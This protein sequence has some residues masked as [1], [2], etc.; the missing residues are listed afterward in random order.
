MQHVMVTTDAGNLHELYFKPAQGVHE[1]VL[2]QLLASA[3]SVQDV[4]PDT[5]NGVVNAG[6]STAGLTVSLAGDTAA[7]YAV[8]LDAGVWKSVAGSAWLR[9]PNAPRPTKT[10]CIP[11]SGIS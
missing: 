2:V 6:P 10:Q 1:D 7:L 8:S 11:T 9:L 5:P 3:P 4:S